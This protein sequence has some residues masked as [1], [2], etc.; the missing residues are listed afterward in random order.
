[1]AVTAIGVFL[2]GVG[3]SL[4]EEWETPTTHDYVALGGAACLLLVGYA[5]VILS[6]RH[7]ELAVVAPF[8]YS[9]ILFAIIMGYLVWG[10]I[11]DRY[12]LIGTAIVVA[13]GAYSFQRERALARR[14]SV[15]RSSG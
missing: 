11:P 4:G 10:D 6:M 14:G 7:G 13:T 9:I 3:V 12:T 2:L 8:R 5:C 1:M 15:S